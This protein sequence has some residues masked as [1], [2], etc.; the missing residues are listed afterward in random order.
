MIRPPFPRS[1]LAC[2]VFATLVPLGCRSL[3]GA[4]EATFGPFT[5]PSEIWPDARGS[6]ADAE[7]AALCADAWELDLASFP[8][9][10]TDLGDPRYND[11]LTDRSLAGVERRV[12]AV[13]R[14]LARAEAIPT[15]RLER[16]DRITLAMLERRWESELD[17]QASGIDQP[18][19]NLVPRS[20]VHVD[21]LTLAADQPVGTAQEREQMLGRWRSMPIAIERQIVNLRRGLAY[22]RVASLEAV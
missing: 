7:L 8:E 13:R 11:E 9:R 14:L 5:T 17:E 22:G 4:S 15:E 21:F 16:Q 6:V 18:S 2:L 12:R 3:V 19:W 1:A 10:A 20:G